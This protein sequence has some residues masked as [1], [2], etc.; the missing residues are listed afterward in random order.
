MYKKFKEKINIILVTK[1]RHVVLIIILLLNLILI[2]GAAVVIS[3][4]APTD[5][6][7]GFW[8]SIFYTIS[9]ILDAGCVQYVV[10]DIGSTNVT[11]IIVCLITVLIGMVTFSGAVIGYI[12][13]YIS[14]FIED[15]N[16]GERPL[17]ISDHTVILNWNNR[18]AEIIHDLLFTEKREVIVVLVNQDKEGTEQ[19]IKDRLSETLKKNPRLAHK[20]TVIVKEGDT[21]STEQLDNISV[22]RAK[23]V[24]IL[25]EDNSGRP[26]SELKD[27]SK[28]GRGN[29]N[30]IKTLIQ[31][32]EMTA[33]ADSLDDQNIIVEVEDDWT[34]KI[35]ETIISHKEKISKCHIIVVPVNKIL[36]SILSQFSI[37]PELN[38]V[39]GE[40]F[41][42]EGAEFFCKKT[43]KP[44]DETTLMEH[45]LDDHAR[46]IPIG[47]RE[48]RK[49]WHEFYVAQS[50]E[51]IRPKM[52]RGSG[53]VEVRLNP[54]FVMEQKNIVILGHNSKSKQLME[55][56]FA[57]RN[58][59]NRQTEAGKKDVLNVIAID[60]KENLERM[61]YYRDCP[62]VVSCVEADIYEDKLICDTIN[63]FVDQNK[64]DTTV[65][66]L[67]DDMAEPEDVDANALTYLVYLHDIIVKRLK[68]DPDFDVERIDV[69]VEIINP[70]NYDVVHNYSVN[71][72]VISNR[73][74]SK[75]LT[76]I[77]SKDAL[78]EMYNDMLSYDDANATQ[79]VSKEMYT[80]PVTQFFEVLPPACSGA[81][82]V[83]S[84]YHASPDDNKSLV[85]GFVSPGGNMTLFTGENLNKTF[86]LQ[87][88]DKI[89]VYSNH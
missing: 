51:D 78:Y 70:K 56:F 85:L 19:K 61:D 39:Y 28:Y 41:S 58:E 72:V 32:A 40:L 36:G 9:M 23:S 13:N 30:T 74:V 26:V 43:D 53:D 67:S 2:G 31:V 71:N 21:Y 52:Y 14:S 15:A 4:L 18:A 86:T 35:C 49:G 6:E 38:L 16:E 7:G 10:A 83:R 65:L 82:L 63:T 42:N 62:F 77:G 79:F 1:P 84:V 45:M 48:T 76:Q 44:L 47:V 20:N 57:F 68:V 25:S 73:Y 22:S 66:I 8:P 69:I 59:W 27:A 88:K 17:V 81:E 11:L 29:A 37:M 87:E 33:S 34:K 3:L 54:N 60:T 24:I 50:I 46:A 75:L 55:G 12:T 89:I 80:K 5:I 64:N